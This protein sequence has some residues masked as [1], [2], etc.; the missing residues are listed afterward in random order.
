MPRRQPAV[1]STLNRKLPPPIQEVQQLVLPQPEEIRLD[2]GIP[3]YVLDYPDQEIVKIEVVYRAGRPDEHKRLAARATARLLRDGSRRHTGAEIA[4]LIDFYGGTFSVPTNLDTSSF[5]LMGLKKYAGELLPVF[6]EALLEPVFPEKELDTFRQTHIAE[7]LVE[8]EK[9]EVR[10][11]REVTERIFGPDHPYGY[12]S[13]PSDYEA[14]TRDDLL[15]HYE[16][17]HVPERCRIFASGRIDEALLARLNALFGQTPSGTHQKD[18]RSFGSEPPSHE[19]PGSVHLSHPGSLQTAIKIGR[20]LF[21]RRHPDFDGIFVLNTLLGGY[22]G[23]RL[24]MNIREKRG[25]TYNIYSTAD[26]MLHDGCFYIATEV[27]SDKAAVTVREIMAEMRHL[28]ERPVEN[29][30]LSMVRGYLLGMLLNGL[31]GPVNASDL[32]RNLI[33]DEL[34]RDAFDRLVHTV[35]HI[36]ATELQALAR[37][38][39]QPEDYWIVTVG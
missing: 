31:D 35:R 3:V 27:N 11:Y 30:E 10:A 23:S 17:C 16:R 29:E 37:K 14:L 4:E 33:V 22:F 36:S 7:L 39:L 12:N 26:A 13:Q 34:P 1:S 32:V 9:P 15:R 20:R 21:P 8:L 5:V 38:Y 2:N 24:M 28:C 6:A 25:Y 18:G 19:K